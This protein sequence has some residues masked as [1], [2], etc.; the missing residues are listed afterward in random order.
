[1]V[2]GVVVM[3]ALLTNQGDDIR[4]CLSWD[5]TVFRVGSFVSTESPVSIGTIS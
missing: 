2:L 5:G 1:M 3:S 4:V